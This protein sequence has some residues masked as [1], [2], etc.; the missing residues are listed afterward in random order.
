MLDW[1]NQVEGGE[2]GALRTPICPYVLFPAPRQTLLIDHNPFSQKSFTIF[3][4]AHSGRRRPREGKA[5]AY[6]HR[7]R[8]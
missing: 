4:A 5:F 1:G 2:E 7:V 6:G 3:Q 8:W